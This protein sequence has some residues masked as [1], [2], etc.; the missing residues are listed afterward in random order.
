MQRW[1]YEYD[2]RRL[3][4]FEAGANRVAAKTV[5]D[6]ETDDDTKQLLQEFYFCQFGLEQGR[7]RVD[8]ID[9]LERLD[10]CKLKLSEAFG[11]EPWELVGEVIDERPSTAN[12]LGRTAVR[13]V[14]PD[15]IGA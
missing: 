13:Q 9:L 3:D 2:S 4:K 8:E 12:V 10:R 14:E 7:G 5:A 6:L 15:A 11:D 1:I